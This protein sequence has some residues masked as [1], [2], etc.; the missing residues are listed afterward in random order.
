MTIFIDI[1]GNLVI[2]YPSLYIIEEICWEIKINS[3]LVLA[4]VQEMLSGMR[5]IHSYK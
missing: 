1:V 2:I 4:M 3:A 5:S